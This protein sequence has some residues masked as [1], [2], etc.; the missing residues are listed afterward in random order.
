MITDN[1][2]PF[3]NVIAHALGMPLSGGYDMT[4]SGTRFRSFSDH[5]RI[6]Y[7]DPDKHEY[8]TAAGRY[9]VT[10]AVYDRYIRKGLVP[11]FSPT[12]QDFIA[13]QQM[14][15]CRALPSIDKGN[16]WIAVEKCSR[17]WEELRKAMIGKNGNFLHELLTVFEQSGGVIN[18]GED[19]V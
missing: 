5:P 9:G 1:R 14:A 16:F 15:D 12:S 6:R 13:I 18:A 2:M 17:Q 3:L 10:D 19:S 7:F 8:T 4:A 11:D